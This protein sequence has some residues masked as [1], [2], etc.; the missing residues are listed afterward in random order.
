LVD[1]AV[2][3]WNDGIVEVLERILGKN[4]Y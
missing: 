4:E 1:K 2:R 3:K